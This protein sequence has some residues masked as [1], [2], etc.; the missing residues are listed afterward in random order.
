MGE[1]ADA[2]EFKDLQNLNKYP[3]LLRKGE[4]FKALM[5]VKDIINTS[6]GCIKSYFLSS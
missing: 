1:L 3:K 5:D 6:R 2:I 4:L